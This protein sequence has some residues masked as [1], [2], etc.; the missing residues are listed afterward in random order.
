MEKSP[1]QNALALT[2]HLDNNEQKKLYKESLEQPIRIKDRIH[3]YVFKKRISLGN[4]ILFKDEPYLTRSKVTVERTPEIDKLLVDLSLNHAAPFFGTDKGKGKINEMADALIFFSA[5][6]FAKENPELC[7]S[8]FFITDETN[9]SKGPTLYENI[10]GHAEEANLNFHCSFKTF[11][12]TE[13]SQTAERYKNAEDKPLF[14]SDSYFKACIKCN[15]E[16]HINADG[17][18][19]HTPVGEY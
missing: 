5:C 11:V 12:D 14:L 18:Y 13:L 19:K 10:K 8:Y 1:L 15:G 17:A 9:F 6:H 2:R 16:I 3:K 7:E 4:D